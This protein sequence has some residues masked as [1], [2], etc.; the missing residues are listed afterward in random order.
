ME[1]KL[2]VL[3]VDDSENLREVV[4]DFIS[5][6]Y[7]CDFIEAGD[8][9]EAEQR[10]QESHA[11]DEPIDVIFLDWMMPKV[12]G[13]TFLKKIRAIEAFKTNPYIIMLTAETYSEQISACFS[14]GV[15]FYL[16]KPFTEKDVVSA[17][18]EVLDGRFGGIKHAI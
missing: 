17:I 11:F 15:N 16:T 8:G 6:H 7:A 18:E 2:R 1:R 14:F 10:L 4:K 12:D 13:I 3:I 5:N 9:E